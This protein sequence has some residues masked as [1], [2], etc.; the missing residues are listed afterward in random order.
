[1]V[2]NYSKR[3]L[4]KCKAL[5]FNFNSSE[6]KTAIGKRTRNIEVVRFSRLTYYCSEISQ[7]VGLID[8][9]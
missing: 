4:L 3:C 6:Y 2:N 5:Y 9:C 1:M 8:V 7:D